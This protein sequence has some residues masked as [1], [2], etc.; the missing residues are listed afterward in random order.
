MS[1]P[2]LAADPLLA[3]LSRNALLDPW[4]VFGVSLVIQVILPSAL[5][6]RSG[7][8]RSEDIDVKPDEEHRAHGYGFFGSHN[9][10]LIA[11][12]LLNLAI[13]SY[14]EVANEN[15]RILAD[16]VSGDQFDASFGALFAVFDTNLSLALVVLS[17]A[18][19]LVVLVHFTRFQGKI[20]LTGGDFLPRTDWLYYQGR[21]R[22]ICYLFSFTTHFLQLSI[23]FNWLFRHALLS[24]SSYDKFFNDPLRGGSLIAFHPDGLFGL[25]A[26]ENVALAT[27]FVL[28]AT[29]L[30]VSVW[31][32]GVVRTKGGW[33]NT[34]RRS[35]GPLAGI[36]T[37][38]V[39]APFSVA[40][41]LA[42][43]HGA[44][45]MTKERATFMLTQQ[46]KAVSSELDTLIGSESLSGVDLDE[47][48][49]R[50]EKLTLVHKAISEVPT[51]PIRLSRL[52][53]IIANLIL[54]LAVPLVIQLMV[55]GVP[56]YGSPRPAG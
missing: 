28:A 13:F 54:P 18:I 8:W 4:M 30:V 16:S 47:L 53:G 20:G 10:Y 38:L 11:F 17:Y 9:L 45:V 23:L 43:S 56:P 32:V 7:V 40:V 41:I 1:N 22:R 12:P 34:T 6:A 33:R 49:A 21:P 2:I 25:G 14:Y 3:F 19:G 39:L 50:R 55:R 15:S 5:A 27:S 42:P 36:V 24:L 35:P 48:W 44:M 29:G 31:V 26:L 51:W 46:I 52:T 37:F